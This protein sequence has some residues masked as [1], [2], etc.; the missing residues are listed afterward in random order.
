MSKVDRDISL[1]ILI[2]TETGPSDLGDLITGFSSQRAN[3]PGPCPR[4][5]Y[6]T[7]SS[8]LTSVFYTGAEVK[9]Q[10]ELKPEPQG[11]SVVGKWVWNKDDSFHLFRSLPK[12][13]LPGEVL[14]PIPIPHATPL[15][16]C[17]IMLFSASFCSSHVASP[18]TYSL[19]YFGFLLPSLFEKETLAVSGWLELPYTIAT[20][21]SG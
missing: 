14:S 19:I 18:H 8:C 15:E 3:Q 5:G 1:G 2:K 4:L 20:L 11:S 21:L 9:T 6:S 10:V 16:P 13:P 17:C 7:L 12:K